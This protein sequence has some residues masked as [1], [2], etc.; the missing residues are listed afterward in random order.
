MKT[1]SGR[2]LITSALIPVGV[3]VTLLLVQAQREKW[4]FS[5]E[6]Q[7]NDVGHSRPAAG[8]T[9]GSRAAAARVSV[10]LTAKQLEMLGV[11][12]E[13]AEVRKLDET[14]PA[15]ASAVIDESRIVEVHPRVSGW[16][17]QLY[18]RTTGQNVGAGQALGAVFSQELYASQ[19]E[20]LAALRRAGTAPASVVLAA[21][22]TRLKVLGMSE[23]EIRRIERTRQ[24][25]RLVT[26]AAPRSG[27]VLDRGATQGITV[28]PSTNIL[29]IADVTRLWII[30][31]V[32]ESD[33]ARI[34]V[35]SSASLTFPLSGRPPFIAR[36]EF[37][38]PTLTE[39]TR[40]VRV[41]M[42]VPNIGGALR[43]GMYGSAQISAAPR[44]VLTIGRDTVVDTGIS[45]H[46]FV[47]GAKNQFEPHPVKLG[48]RVGDRVEVLEGLVVGEQVVSAGVFLLDSESRLRASGATG[49]GGHG[50]GSQP[51]PKREGNAPPTKA[52]AQHEHQP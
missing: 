6:H 38:Y 16:L 27:F 18:V 2:A 28:D 44:Y 1:Y 32:A 22:R 46:V 21:G 11:Q 50:G 13:T 3:L 45:Q 49:H 26:I 7:T 41:R 33:A 42:A 39:R 35:G 8:K 30:A 24:A 19:L 29:S 5:P 51:A 20:Y 43:P 9:E 40:S 48:T 47:R 17:E 37:I 34:H 23:A 36:V 15:V 52:P 12:F 25:D 31:E 4:P 14:V 10:E